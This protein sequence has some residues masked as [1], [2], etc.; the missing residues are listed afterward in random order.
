MK[1]EIAESIAAAGK[2]GV[3]TIAGA[4][5]L[6]YTL[7]DAAAFAAL[8]YTSLLIAKFLV[9]ATLRFV[10]WMRARKSPGV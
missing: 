8:V 6:G 7:G 5:I 9:D 10:R 1:S 4:S 3:I 2:A